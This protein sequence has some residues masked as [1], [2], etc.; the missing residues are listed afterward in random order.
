MLYCMYGN[1]VMYSGKRQILFLL[2]YYFSYLQC[3]LS[4]KCSFF[5]YH[6]CVT[7]RRAQKLR[8]F[9]MKT[10]ALGVGNKKDNRQR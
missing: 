7:Y 9:R 4:C 10:I 8:I 5:L 1:S 6:V 2:F 3:Y